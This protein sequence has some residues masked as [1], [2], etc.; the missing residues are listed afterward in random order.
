MS[1]VTQNL[2][3]ISSRCVACD[4]QTIVPWPFEC[5]CW[6]QFTAQRGGSRNLKLCLS[7]WLLQGLLSIKFFF[8]DVVAMHMLLLIIGGKSIFR[9][10]MSH[11]H[12]TLDSVFIFMVLK[13]NLHTYPFLRLQVYKLLTSYTTSCHTC[14]VRLK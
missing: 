10:Q 9:E 5:T 1:H 12:S 14:H 2:H 6:R 8:H 11:T 7:R 13:Q 4:L 3:R